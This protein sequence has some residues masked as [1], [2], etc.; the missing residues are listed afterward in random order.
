MNCDT[1]QSSEQLPEKSLQ[2]QPRSN[3]NPT[4]INYAA[5]PVELIRYGGI[6]PRSYMRIIRKGLPVRIQIPVRR[7]ASRL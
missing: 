1:Q 2:P 6:F 3:A 5:A 4:K 7:A